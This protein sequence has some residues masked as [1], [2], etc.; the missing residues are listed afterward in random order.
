[1][2]VEEKI[3]NMARL[4]EKGAGKA[5]R[6]NNSGNRTDAAHRR[7]QAAKGRSKQ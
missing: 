1:M 6:R 5:P 4:E 7:A 2:R 3:N